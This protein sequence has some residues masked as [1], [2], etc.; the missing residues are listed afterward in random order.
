MSIISASLLLSSFFFFHSI[1]LCF[2]Y[3][4]I[5][6]YLLYG[7]ALQNA[8]VSRLHFLVFNVESEECVFSPKRAPRNAKN[9]RGKGIN[10]PIKIGEEYEVDIVDMSPNGQGIA[11]IKGFPI[12]I[13]DAKPNEHLK[14]KITNLTSGCADAQIIP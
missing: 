1:S 3:H 7:S 8:Y 6:P 2:S 13:S 11:R 4:G 5:T 12:F 10:Y 9:K 14:I